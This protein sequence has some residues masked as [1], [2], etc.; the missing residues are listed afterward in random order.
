MEAILVV[1][2][3][4][5]GLAAAF[6]IALGA[7]LNNPRHHALRHVQTRSS[8]PTKRRRNKGAAKHQRGRR[9]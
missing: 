4:G 2:A 7:I 3:V 1:A 9:E 5:L 6:A 8:A